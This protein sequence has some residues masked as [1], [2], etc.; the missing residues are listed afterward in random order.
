MNCLLCY[1]TISKHT[2]FNNCC[3]LTCFNIN[4]NTHIRWHTKSIILIDCEKG[5]NEL[6]N[7]NEMKYTPQP[8]PSL[9]EN[10]NIII[11]ITNTK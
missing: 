2:S 5:E 7:T 11:K 3:D 8:Q 4:N 6:N 10:I 9:L 1:R